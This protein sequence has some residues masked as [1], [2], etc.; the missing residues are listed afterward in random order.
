MGLS[1]A[2]LQLQPDTMSPKNRL[3]MLKAM[4]NK[5]N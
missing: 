4:L 5:K 2:S 3:E 1:E